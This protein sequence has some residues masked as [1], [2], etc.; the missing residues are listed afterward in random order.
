MMRPFRIHIPQATL[1]DLHRRIDQT[2]WP[3]ELPGVGW[4]RGVPLNYL[5]ELTGYWRNGYDW[6]AAEARLNRFA[7][8][9]T[10]IDGVNVHFLHVRSPEPDATP[11]ILTHGW[12]GSSAD[13]L[14]VIE[15]LVDPRAHG[16]DPAD[17]FHV[18]VPTLPGF[19]FS[20]PV[21]QT[22]WHTGRIASAWA[23]LMRRLGYHE[24]LAQG[25]DFGT[26]I[27]LMLSGA[28]PER[29]AGVHV[30]MLLTRPPDGF[31]DTAELS[32]SDQAR[33][34][35]LP[36]FQ[37]EGSG[38][39][40]LQSTRPQTLAYGLTDSPVGQLAWILEKYR[41]WS[42]CQHLPEEA[43]DR[44]ELLTSVTIYW[45]TATAGSSAQL[46]YEIVDILPIS[47]IERRP[48]PIPVPLGVGVYP[49]DMF[50][51]VRRFADLDYPNI[52]HWREFDRGGHFPAM[53]EPD[54]F[55]ADLREYRRA[56][57]RYRKSESRP[58]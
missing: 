45:L 12:P 16:G 20:G 49:R 25:G 58:A 51:P 46:Y 56:L 26:V 38:Y 32:D 28:D 43:I 1:D 33:L 52:I 35:L 11:I 57:D 6:R 41:E 22:G 29:V 10:D 50:L 5:K 40:K 3:E 17:A 23:E 30:N 31:T 14:S 44:D 36:R 34:A 13:Y 4:E 42:D 39:M 7:Q 48:P 21:C 24:Y 8:F 47:T 27:A 9:T 37:Q 15:P 18:V 55:V 54:L 19:G 2:R 53:E